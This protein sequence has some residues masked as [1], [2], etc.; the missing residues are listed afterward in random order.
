MKITD[1]SP[2]GAASSKRISVT[3]TPPTQ[4]FSN[5]S[6][7]EDLS[8]NMNAP[9]LHKRDWRTDQLIE[10]AGDDGY[11]TANEAPRMTKMKG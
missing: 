10:M 11:R 9:E 8:T 7:S 3:D 4:G 5:V 1:M 2:N 6:Q